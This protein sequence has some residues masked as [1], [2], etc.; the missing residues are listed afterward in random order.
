MRT[1]QE[2]DQ[3]G[4]KENL[5]TTYQITSLEDFDRFLANLIPALM[6]ANPAAWP[7]TKIA[8]DKI[9]EDTRAELSL[10]LKRRGKTIHLIDG[11]DR[12]AW[13]EEV[14]MFGKSV[15]KV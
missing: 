6:A 2:Y 4:V 12:V 5:K 14:R 13:E 1:S 11:A 9:V 10:T 8:L 3:T 15:K 7:V